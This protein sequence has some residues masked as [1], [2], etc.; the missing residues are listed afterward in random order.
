M[1][2]R[3]SFSEHLLQGIFL[4]QGL[5]PHFLCLLPGDPSLTCELS[6]AFSEVQMD[7]RKHVK[8]SFISP[9]LVSPMIDPHQFFYLLFNHPS[10]Q[11]LI[12]V[13]PHVHIHFSVNATHVHA[14]ACM[15]ANTHTHTHTS[16]PPSLPTHP[17]V[18]SIFVKEN[19][20]DITMETVE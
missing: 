18:T 16:L 1:D 7:T 3:Q 5:N 8:E 11:T 15:H 10:L 14:C 2:L 13:L 20:D 4:I 19:E 6:P 12:Y 9:I 17:V